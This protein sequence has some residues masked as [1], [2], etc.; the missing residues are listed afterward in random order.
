MFSRKVTA[1]VRR[2]ESVEKELKAL[3]DGSATK[4]DIHRV[5]A[6]VKKLYDGLHV[7]ALVHGMILS[8]SI[9]LLITPSRVPGPAVT[10]MGN[11]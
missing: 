10:C 7:G 3:A 5:R 1:H 8:F 6:E 4:E 2:I 9:H 11:A